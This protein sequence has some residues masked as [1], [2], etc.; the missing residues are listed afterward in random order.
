M[1]SINR[2]GKRIRLALKINLSSEYMMFMGL[3]LGLL[4]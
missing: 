4:F 3:E 2:L 1:P